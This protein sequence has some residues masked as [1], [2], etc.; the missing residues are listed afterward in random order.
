MAL[1]LCRE[2]YGGNTPLQLLTILFTILI[3][4]V[5]CSM[6]TRNLVWAKALPIH[7]YEWIERTV[8]IRCSCV[9]NARKAKHEHVSHA[10]FIHKHDYAA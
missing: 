5:W 6:S 4:W 2:S 3:Q 9:F 1:T 8:I 7:Y 10:L